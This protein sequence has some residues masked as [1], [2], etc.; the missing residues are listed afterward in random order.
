MS[1]HTNQKSLPNG[2]YIVEEAKEVDDYNARPSGHGL[3]WLTVWLKVGKFEERFVVLAAISTY[4][5]P[6]LMDALVIS[7][8]LDCKERDDLTCQCL[9]TCS[10]SGD[11][12]GRCGCDGACTCVSE[13]GCEGDCGGRCGCEGVC[14]CVRECGCEGDCGGRCGCLHTPIV[15]DPC[16]EE[17]DPWERDENDDDDEDDDACEQ[18]PDY[19]PT[20]PHPLPGQKASSRSIHRRKCGSCGV[21]FQSMYRGKRALCRKHRH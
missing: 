1:T 6:E 9:S 16:E 5:T 10:C 2:W 4:S 17:V 18:D 12:N 15:V 20:S 21:F 14:V 8:S 3:V 11:C 19:I 7:L 13:C